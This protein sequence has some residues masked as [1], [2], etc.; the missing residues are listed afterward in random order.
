MFIMHRYKRE[1]C[2]GVHPTGG[3]CTDIE[4]PH[5]PRY[6]CAQQKKFNQ[7]NQDWMTGHG[8][9][10][11]TCGHCREYSSVACPSCFFVLGADALVGVR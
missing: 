10:K 3:I 1:A 9:C 8:F 4:P 2:L 7:C 5:V 11:A 6:T